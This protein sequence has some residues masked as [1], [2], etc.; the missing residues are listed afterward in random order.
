MLGVVLPGLPTTEFVLLAAWAA[1]RSSP[2]LSA[3]LENHRLFGPLLVN[4]RDGGII[5]R[6]TKLASA[7]SMLIALLIML[8]TVDHRPSILFAA[9]GMA[10]GAAWIW[11]RPEHRT[12]SKRSDEPQASLGET[13]LPSKSRP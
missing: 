4:W 2:R 3:W 1:S 5:T 8:L 6:K 12:S 7:L 10:C 9:L 11:S 13:P